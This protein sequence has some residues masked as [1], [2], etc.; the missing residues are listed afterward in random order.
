MRKLHVSFAAF[1]ALAGLA[2]GLAQTADAAGGASRQIP[3]FFDGNAITINVFELPNSDPLIRSNPRVNTIYVSNDLD[4]DQEFD[5]VIN[6]IQGDPSFAPLWLQVIYT[7][8]E[9]FTPHQ[10][11]SEAEVLAAAA[12]GEITLTFTD[13]VYICAVVG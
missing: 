7:F 13:E 8:N 4:D 12:L 11:V 3:A 6:R 9:G 1:V 2:F 5:P 10:F